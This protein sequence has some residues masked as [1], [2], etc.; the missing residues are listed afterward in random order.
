MGAHSELNS[1][2]SSRILWRTAVIVIWTEQAGLKVREHA[3]TEVVSAHGALLRL[4]S[5]LHSGK[6][7]DLLDPRTNEC[8]AARVVWSRRD[9]GQEAHAGIELTT[10]SENFWGLHI[11]IPTV[12][13]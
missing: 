1:R 3:Q 5:P 4:E 9:V 8:R 12:L 11:P 6:R 10:P 7:V 2:R 13:R